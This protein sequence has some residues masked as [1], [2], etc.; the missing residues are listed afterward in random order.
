MKGRVVSYIIASL[1]A[2]TFILPGF[3][4]ERGSAPLMMDEP[5]IIR[6]IITRLPL[7]A[8]LLVM[9]LAGTP[10]DRRRR[11]W[12]GLKRPDILIIPALVLITFIT[13]ILM[14][15]ESEPFYSLNSLTPGLTALV[16][17]MSVSGAFVEELFFRSWLLS[18]LDDLGWR[19][20]PALMVSTVLF[21]L[22]HTWQGWRG[23]L[24]AAVAGLAYGLA[25]Q[26]RRSIAPL[27]AAHSVHNT[28]ALILA[29]LG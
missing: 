23:L 17:L 16:I 5:L 13:G 25:F 26:R 10:D 6:T 21:T 27:I 14:P 11:G 20:L 28:A 1:S 19:A 3:T 18:E 15:S 24:S 4:G 22:T 7:L 12:A 29:S 2:L 9:T 8:V